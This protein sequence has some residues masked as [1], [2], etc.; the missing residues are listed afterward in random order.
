MR[1][2]HLERDCSHACLIPFIQTMP[3]P[4]TP[5]ALPTAPAT[6]TCGPIIL[7]FVEIVPGDT[8]L[9]LVPSYHFR[10]LTAEG[11]DVGHINF[12]IG[13]TRHIR[14]CAGHLG[15]AIHEPHR[16]HGYARQAC[17]ALAPFIRTVSPA[18]L[19]TCNPDNFASRRTI[20]RLGAKFI[21][22]VAVSAA[23]AH[24]DRHARRK[25]RYQWT[26]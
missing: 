5:P 10:I 15:F 11:V 26:P 8:V 25:R 4:T 16:G 7:R 17:L 22:E 2:D 24:H 13:K 19:I 14:N 18:V 1:S 21:D 12:R 9:D 3:A 23:D 6:L 20:E